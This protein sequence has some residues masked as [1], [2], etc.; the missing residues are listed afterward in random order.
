MF[1]GFMINAWLSGTMVAIIAGVVGFFVVLRGSAFPAHAIPNGAFAGAAAANYILQ[2]I[3]GL[4]ANITPAP[5]TIVGVTANDKNYDAT[6]VATLSDAGATLSGVLGSDQVGLSSTAATG[7]FSQVNVGSN[8][9]VNIGGF[10][11]TGSAAGNYSVN[12]PGGLTASILRAPL[13]ATI[14]S[15]I[16]KRSLCAPPSA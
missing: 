2:P 7:Q 3:A 11:L 14:I 4:T 15:S 1:S 5:L 16:I 13:T 6:N 9:P 10:S 8:L 12:Q